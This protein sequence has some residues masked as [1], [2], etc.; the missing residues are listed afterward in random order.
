MNTPKKRNQE[1]GQVIVLLAIGLLALLGL[2]AV[3]LDGGMIYA[4]R[5]FD[6]N[7][8]DAASYAGAGIAAMT[9]ENK[10]VTYDSFKC[11]GNSGVT[12]AKADAVDAAIARAASNNFAIDND[13]TDQHGVTVECGV[14]T[15]GVLV[16]K[17][18]DVRTLISSDL[19]TAFAHLFYDRPVRNS[20]E[21]VARARPRTDPAYG[22]AITALGESCG[23][24]VEFDG[25]AAVNVRVT[26]IFSNSCITRNGGVE[27]TTIPREGETDL[28]PVSWVSGSD[29]I[30]HGGSG[31]IAATKVQSPVPMPRIPVPPPNC[32]ADGMEDRSSPKWTGHT[33]EITIDP[34]RY[35]TI[36]VNA[37]NTLKMN[38][39]LY[40]ISTKLTAL[41]GELTGD[42]ITIYMTS[43]PMSI[44]GNVNVQLAAPT[45][46]ADP[47]MR[48][49]L[50]Y[51]AESNTSAHSLSG[52][53]TSKYT[54]T[55]YAPYGDVT[56]GG[57]SEIGL[58][59]VTQIIA[60]YV[61][62]H[63]TADIDIRFDDQVIWKRPAYVEL[64]R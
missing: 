34:G 20:V 5:R 9:M 54:G 33:T 49:M 44:G 57:N 36:K 13:V 46:P 21:A 52:G 41:G 38:P 15:K 56:V 27:V 7:A 1:S 11:S 55:I 29:I 64:Y 51:A 16:D 58:T 53:A 40:C 18:I 12:T 17:F 26:G 6:Q 28:P 61:K 45:G 50:F 35:T 48:G 63:G 24:G 32:Y 2:T 37:G 3:A 31:Y 39:G 14:E 30:E 59:Y 43:G 23:E 60:N 47:A 10:G 62:V 25:D 22:F 4:D 19:Q 8:A 42:G